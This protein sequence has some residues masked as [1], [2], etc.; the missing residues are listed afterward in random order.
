[1]EDQNYPAAAER[2]KAARSKKQVSGE[3]VTGHEIECTHI[4]TMNDL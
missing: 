3:E 2:K 4:H 1:V